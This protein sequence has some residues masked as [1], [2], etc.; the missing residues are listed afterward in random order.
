MN[1]IRDEE[2]HGIMMIPL[3]SQWGVTRCNVAK[4]TEKPTTIITG[5]INKPIG[6]CE[7]HYKEC[8]ETGKIDYTLYWCSIEEEITTN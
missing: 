8:K 7:K 3:L 4:C 6:L 2:M 5:V 1:I